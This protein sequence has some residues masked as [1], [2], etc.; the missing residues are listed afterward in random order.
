M[1][2]GPHAVQPHAACVL[3]GLGDAV[4]RF[5]HFAAFLGTLNLLLSGCGSQRL[6]L[7][8]PENETADPPRQSSEPESRLLDDPMLRDAHLT[9][10]FGEDVEAVA[11]IRLMSIRHSPFMKALTAAG[12]E[13][14]DG[15]LELH[16]GIH[17]SD[18]YTVTFGLRG[19]SELDAETLR[20]GPAVLERVTPSLLA[21]IRTANPMNPSL[22]S[23]QPEFSRREHAG[24]TYYRRNA[25]NPSEPDMAFCMPHDMTLLVG[26]EEEVRAATERRSGRPDSRLSFVDSEADLVIALCPRDASVFRSWPLPELKPGYSAF[27][28]TVQQHVERL[29]LEVN[30][31]EEIELACRFE[32]DSPAPAA[33]LAEAAG[34]MIELAR[35]DLEKQGEDLA[36]FLGILRPLVDRLEGTAD[37]S[38]ATI[39]TSLPPEAAKLIAEIVPA[40]ASG[41]RQEEFSDSRFRRDSVDQLL[42]AARPAERL[43]G[44]DE[45]AELHAALVWEETAIPPEADGGQAPPQLKAHLILRG[46]KV[47]RAVGYGKHRVLSCRVDRGRL[48]QAQ[49]T[50]TADAARE[51][52][53]FDRR[54]WPPMPED[55]LI[56]PLAFHYPQDAPREIEELSGSFEL[57][58]SGRDVRKMISD[59]KHLVRFPHED[60]DLEAAGFDI[61]LQRSS[62]EDAPETIVVSLNPSNVLAEMDIS[63]FKQPDERIW[64]DRRLLPDGSSHYL[65]TTG[66]GP[67]PDGVQVEGTLHSDLETITVNYRFEG[68]RIPEM[69]AEVSD[70]QKALAAWFPSSASQPPPEG[71]ELAARAR[72]STLTNFD[73][74][75][76]PLP[77]DLEVAID[78]TGP[79][80]VQT[81]ALGR[82]QI[83]SARAGDADLRVQREGFGTFQAALRDLELYDP[84]GFSTQ[85]PPDGVQAVL[86]FQRPRT[87]P[88]AIEDVTGRLSLI[89]A[90]S[91]RV[92]TLENIL[93]SLGREISHPVLEEAGVKLVPQEESGVINILVEAESPFSVT[94]MEAVDPH[95]HVYRDVYVGRSHN[96]KT[97]EFS[98]LPEDELP[99]QV[100]L[101]ITL[102]EGLET[103]EIPFRFERLPLGREPPPGQF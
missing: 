1:S 19:L 50:F 38:T 103:H 6:P 42:S 45:E 78:L 52:I 61:R 68:L 56:I 46:G 95:G 100:G 5:I 14:H 32:C 93:D 54:G 10:Y 72:W 87:A 34:D 80:A 3:A 22:L 20:H 63:R 70:E 102:H 41:F 96:Q 53:L 43:D 31:S 90:S 25:V 89:T 92:F 39:S 58:V 62:F 11:R 99:Q 60:E 8:L 59:L 55:G 81:I 73:S 65:F 35:G 33:A 84:L 28:S 67:F 30:F 101:R 17:V 57:L 88:E 21:V 74:E 97:V 71:I 15:T 76:T 23:R 47:R 18:V 4:R 64:P 66:D 29:A 24:L 36:M 82:Y 69:N 98:L 48:K 27:L 2:T 7:E 91:R 12:I 83:D 44:L 9:A 85:L 51:I 37:G 75:G 79:R 26:P 94:A 77:R 49:A 86:L 16:S 40:L 13:I